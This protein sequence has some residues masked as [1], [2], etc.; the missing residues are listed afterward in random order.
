MPRLPIL[1]GARIIKTLRRM[2]Y[3]P[4]RQRGSHV[5][6]VHPK[7]PQWPTTVPMYKTIDRSLLRIILQEVHLSI[8]EFLEKL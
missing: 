4:V 1:S 3:V 2:G 6:L 5:R 7:R 8:E